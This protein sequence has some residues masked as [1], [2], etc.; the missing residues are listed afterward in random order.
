MRKICYM[1]ALSVPDTTVVR[2]ECQEFLDQGEFWFSE[3]SVLVPVAAVMISNIC[4]E[5]R[6]T[7]F[8]LL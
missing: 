3:S 5:V 1:H 7:R 2:E 4:T 6:Q 8:P